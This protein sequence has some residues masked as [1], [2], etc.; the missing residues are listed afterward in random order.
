M[1]L[2][3]M[4]HAWLLLALAAL[5]GQADEKTFNGRWLIEVKSDSGNSDAGPWWLEVTGAGSGKSAGS[6]YGATGGRVAPFVEAHFQDGELGFTVERL[7][8]KAEGYDEPKLIQ[9]ESTVRLSGDAVH[10]TTTRQDRE[11]TWVGRRAPE[12]RETDDGTWQEEKPVVLFDGKHLSHWDTLHAGRKHEWLVRDGV[13][14]NKVGADILVSNETF[15]NFKLHVE[16]R[17]PPGTNSGIGLR[18]R[19]EVQILDDYGQPPGPQGNGAIYSRI[20]P[21]LNA[22][23]P[24]G[25]WQT[26]DVTL[27]GREVSVVLN[28]RRIIHK[29]EIAGLCGMPTDSREDQPGPVTLQGSKAPIE[30]RK[31][32][33]T[34]LVRR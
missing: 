12:L 33:V 5:P 31:I 2:K 22:S 30:F 32:V 1:K 17:V 3:T 7:Y 34:P 10:G 9:A 13:L 20:T 24:A 15:W 29:Q 21:S 19:Y 11:F 27:I 4:R 16:Y 23:R 14:T 26:V 18:A 28:G 25:E 6:F 8:G